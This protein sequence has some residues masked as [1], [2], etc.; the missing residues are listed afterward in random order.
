MFKRCCTHP[1]A[2][3]WPFAVW[4]YP[5]CCRMA[6]CVFAAPSPCCTPVFPRQSIVWKDCFASP[7]LRCELLTCSPRSLAGRS[8]L[9]TLSVERS[10]RLSGRVAGFV[11]IPVPAGKPATE[12]IL[13]EFMLDGKPP[14]RFSVG[15]RWDR[16]EGC[17]LPTA[18]D[19][20]LDTCE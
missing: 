13:I 8:Q 5:S 11:Q 2:F 1:P 4:P 16:K 18:T 14:V 3:I 17:S 6:S 12:L 7:L 20:M 15:S 10:E 9:R 19:V